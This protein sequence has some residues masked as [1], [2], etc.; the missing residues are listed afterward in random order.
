MRKPIDILGLGAVAVDDL[1]FVDSY[2][3]A[4][5][6]TR[7]LRCERQCGGL[8]ATALVA[9]ARLG[10]RCAY[11]GV[12]GQDELSCFAARRLEQEGID[13]TRAH[14]APRAR[15]IHSTIVVDS[16][17]GTRNIFFSLD[18][19]IG[20]GARWPTP[21]VLLSCRVLLVDNIGVPGM[22]RAARIARR[23]RIPVVGDLDGTQH[24]RFAELLGL[25]DHLIVSRSFACRV[26]STTSAARA[27]KA[28]WTTDRQVVAVTCGEVGCW[29]LGNGMAAPQHQPAFKVKV[30][31]TTGCGDVFH[32]AY[33]A[34]L[35]R[36]LPLAARLRLGAAAAALKA[37]RP[38]GQAG[39]PTL[40][41]V[42][43]FLEGHHE[44][45]GI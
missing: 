25:A 10:V 23:A 16:A 7:V 27:V 35:A 32:G 28:L 26:T 41:E 31:D 30:V 22:V 45:P 20:A 34:A 6:K 37:S 5:A 15:P 12:L 1:L 13:L 17:H 18:R 38:G 21:A 40:N 2:P 44:D 19:V 14:R 42:R 9:A 29:Y 24:P 3:P 4:D 43:S 11:A 8:T 39:I 36:D 33:A